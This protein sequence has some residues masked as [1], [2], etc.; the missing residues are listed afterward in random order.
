VAHDVV[1][2][3]RLDNGDSNE[4][5]LMHPTKAPKFATFV[6]AAVEDQAANADCSQIFDLEDL[7]REWRRLNHGEPATRRRDG[8]T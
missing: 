4:P 1:N 6:T 5:V 3:H 2:G 8:G 7:R